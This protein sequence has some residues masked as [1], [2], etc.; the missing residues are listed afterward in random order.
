MERSLCLLLGKDPLLD[1]S[2]LLKL[3]KPT[4]NFKA[5]DA[6]TMN[7][8][9]SK[10]IREHFQDQIEYFL[11]IKNSNNKDSIVI[12]EFPTNDDELPRKVRVLY[13]GV[14]SRVQDILNNDAFLRYMV[15]EDEFKKGPLKLFSGYE[16]D[17]V[18]IRNGQNY[19]KEE[20]KVILNKWKN[21]TLKSSYYGTDRLRKVLKMYE[22]WCHN[23]KIRMPRVKISER[24]KILA[25]IK[26]EQYKSKLK[27]FQ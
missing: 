1:E 27:D 18:L 24:Q 15:E 10:E 4:T 14:A 17:V 21:T 25:M 22:Q 2:N 3:T 7:F 11:T 19:T 8:K 5:L 9:D 23:N 16:T 12:I 6:F 20:R 26:K 13:M